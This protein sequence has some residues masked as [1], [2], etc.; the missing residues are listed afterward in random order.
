MSYGT[1]AGSPGPVSPRVGEV[2][3][4][5]LQ[6]NEPDKVFLVCLLTVGTGRFECRRTTGNIIVVHLTLITH[7][8]WMQGVYN[9]D[10]AP[11]QPFILLFPIGMIMIWDRGHSSC[12]RLYGRGMPQII[13][14][15]YDRNL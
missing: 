4:I 7:K 9:F 10:D 12:V 13:L 8:Y 3:T 1:W 5:M 11:P 15:A 2:F 6:G 14:S